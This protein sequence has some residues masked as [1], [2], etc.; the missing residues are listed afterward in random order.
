MLAKILMPSKYAVGNAV[1]GCIHR[2]WALFRTGVI[3]GVYRTA[4]AQVQSEQI[5]DFNTGQ[6]KAHLKICVHEVK[7]QTDVG[8]LAKH[9]Q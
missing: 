6:Q 2:G 7:D 9:I 5:R 3:S 4:I 1:P 8:S